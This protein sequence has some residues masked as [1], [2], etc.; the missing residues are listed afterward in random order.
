[1]RRVER[2]QQCFADAVAMAEPAAMCTVDADHFKRI[3]DSRGH[4][5]GDLALQRIARIATSQMDTQFVFD[6]L[7]GEEFGLLMP[8]TGADIAQAQAERIRL[9]IAQDHRQ[10]DGLGCPLTV[11]LGLAML[12]ASVMADPEAWQ[13]A[14]DQALYRAKALGRNRVELASGVPPT[15]PQEPAAADSGL[16]LPAPRPR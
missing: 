10:S 6:R 9:A 14:A 11:S 8:R 13:M 15:A 4:Q 12:D 3:N 7:G 2:M 1:M 5:A 16:S